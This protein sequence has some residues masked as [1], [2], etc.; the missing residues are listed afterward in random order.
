MLRLT[1]RT[2]LAYLD[3]LLEP[4]DAQE[5]AQKLTESEF[6]MSL[7]RRVRN[8]TRHLPLEKCQLA[9]DGAYDASAIAEYLDNM[10][11]PERVPEFERACLESDSLLAEIGSAHQILAIVLAEPAELSATMRQRIIDSANSPAN[12]SEPSSAPPP[13]L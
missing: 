1:M 5:I 9:E 7:M 12:E 6:A 3:E 2:L 11:P 10:L 8:V 13:T 4:A